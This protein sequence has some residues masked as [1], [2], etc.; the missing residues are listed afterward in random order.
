MTLTCAPL[1]ARPTKCS[2]PML[3]ANSA[4]GE[5][6]K[7]EKKGNKAG[8][9]SVQTRCWTQIALI[10]GQKEKRKKK[11][12]KKEKRNKEGKGSVET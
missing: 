9:V 2:D 8:K 10:G 4:G 12:R 11:K 5:K 7:K 3:D 1:P 6:K